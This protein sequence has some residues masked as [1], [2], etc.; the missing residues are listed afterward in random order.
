M[1]ETQKQQLGKKGEE[2]VAR[3]LQNNGHRI[4]A[5]NFRFGK[6]E[7]DIISR[8][9]NTLVISEVKSYFSRPLGAAEFRV[10]KKK[11]RQI[12]NGTYGFLSRNPQY[13]NMSVRF[14]ILIVNFSV[15]PADIRH[16]KGAFWD[17]QGWEC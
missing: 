6:S 12:I 10:D 7:L 1:P 8:Q 4:I 5:R 15:Y 13:E 14:D 11:Q 17:E 3:Y 16:Y 2:F 9:G